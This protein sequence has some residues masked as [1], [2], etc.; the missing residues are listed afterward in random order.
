M[1]LKINSPDR[2]Y[3]PTRLQAL[4][5]RGQTLGKELKYSGGLDTFV[6]LF[7]YFKV[8]IKMFLCLEC[9]GVT[10][11]CAFAKTHRAIHEN[12]SYLL[13]VLYVLVKTL[14]IKGI[15]L[16]WGRMRICMEAVGSEGSS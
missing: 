7:I 11:P 2:L 4:E 10:Q 9:V 6:Y 12:G 13:C 8:R 1:K 3:S 5:G 15:S 14:R 16:V